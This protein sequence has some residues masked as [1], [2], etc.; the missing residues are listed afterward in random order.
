MIPSERENIFSRLRES[1]WQY[2]HVLFAKDGLLYNVFFFYKALRP[3]SHILAFL[4]LFSGIGYVNYVSSYSFV[5]VQ[6]NVLKEGVIVGEAKPTRINPIL[7]TNNQLENDLSRLIYY[8]LVRVNAAGD[9]VPM[10]ADS[11]DEG[12]DSGK[13]YVFTLREDVLWHDGERFT[14]DDVIATFGALKALGLEEESGI[15]SKRIDIATNLEVIKNDAFT[16][17][18]RLEDFIPTFFEDISVG[19]LPE[20]VLE[21]VSLSTLSRARFNQQPVGTGPFVLKSY[22]DDVITLVANMD[23]FGE[24]PKV[25]QLQIVLFETGD[26][27][28]LAIKNGEIHMLADPSTTVIESLQ[29]WE[30]IKKIESASLYR[31]YWALYFNMKDGGPKI[32]Q[33]K[34]VRQ[35]ISSAINRQDIIS[36]VE[37][38]GE[39]VTGPI[40]ENSWAYSEDIDRF[41]YKYE[42]AVELLEEAGWE[43]K[44]VGGKTV[45]IK[46]DTVLRFELSY[47][48][49]YDRQVVAESIKADLEKL[50]VVVNLDPR[51]SSDL[52]E[53]LI[54]TRNFETVLYGVETPIDPD[55]IRLWHSRAIT[56]P[57]LNI[58]SYETEETGAVIGEDKQIE[59]VSIIDTALENGRSTPDREERMGASG[60]DVGY[61]K[62]QEVLLDETPVVFLY[63]P[64]FTYVAHSRV[65]GINLSEMTVP[66]DRYLSV[67]EWYIE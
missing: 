42:R 62:F 6:R 67:N 11:W 61:T 26:D 32:F 24:K 41:D 39:E 65:N 51:N 55:R 9:V 22:K 52:N 50:G 37:S 25:Q 8:P 57:G 63:H 46:D 2:P 27:A 60:I 48:D 64:V 54:A 31:R 58:S 59:R 21:D 4:V 34:L 33:E 47:L 30:N 35:A 20:H 17:T 29:K 66:D 43:K 12:D 49:K 56:Y 7:P 53:A 45:R 16:V 19:I 40:P 28:V 38:A 5:K 36:Q 14:A 13:E 1:I 10:L 18:F 44:E 3:I 23:F 15:S